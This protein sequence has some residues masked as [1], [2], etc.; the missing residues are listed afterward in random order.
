MKLKRRILSGLFVLALLLSLVPALTAETGA[1]AAKY[2]YIGDSENLIT[3]KDNAGKDLVRGTGW[4]YNKESKV[5]T[6]YDS[7]RLTSVHYRSSDNRAY[8]IHG[9][10]DLTIRVSGP[11]DIAPTYNGSCKYLYGIGVSGSLTIENVTSNDTLSVG[12][13]LG[14]GGK[15]EDAAGINCA[16]KLIVKNVTVDVT[17]PEV[18]FR[19]YGIYAN[20]AE[21]QSAKVTARTMPATGEHSESYGI[22]V[23]GD[24][25]VSGTADVTGI[26]GKAI[27]SHGIYVGTAY[28][29][30]LQNS[31][32]VTGQS[33]ATTGAT[34]IGVEC[35]KLVCQN[36][37]HLTGIGGSADESRS[38]GVKLHGDAV[39][40]VT[41]TTAGV[42][43]TGGAVTG[44]ASS[45]GI[46]VSSTSLTTVELT[47]GKLICTGG[48]AEQSRGYCYG[49]YGRSRILV[50]GGEMRA[51]AADA[52]AKGTGIHLT[53]DTSGIEVSGKGCVIAQGSSAALSAQR[54]GSLAAAPS[55]RAGADYDGADAVWIGT[56]CTLQ[57]NSWHYVAL[58]STAPKF[59]SEPYIKDGRNGDKVVAFSA[60][61]PRGGAVRF[62][63]AWYDA[64][65]RLLGAN[66]SPEFT[67]KK[68]NWTLSVDEGAALYKLM[69][70][71]ALSFVPLCPAWS[72]N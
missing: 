2:L 16:G 60:Q 17:V 69:Y 25:T 53:G 18:S 10:D 9:N 23:Q 61:V 38:I 15:T 36:A 49:F 3:M 45:Y 8:G 29:M 13:K 11:C 35:G 59:T 31:A 39:I 56:S 42:E 67:A 27:S 7:F 64:D 48:S 21:F 66:V 1:A 47:G 33:V 44:K 5:L 57:G 46:E 63:A 51:E 70:V 58:D 30:T 19:N 40:N 34:T 24:F 22:G 71:D 55:I 52:S 20:G 68:I 14:T 32:Q 50:S 37:A 65:G 41:A 26:G 6:L 62:I 4:L 54:P 12:P 43:A 72:G 28:T